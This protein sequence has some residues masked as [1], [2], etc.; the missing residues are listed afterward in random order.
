MLA[1]GCSVAGESYWVYKFDV[2]LVVGIGSGLYVP[3]CRDY[4]FET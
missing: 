3:C 1:L 2:L 4:E